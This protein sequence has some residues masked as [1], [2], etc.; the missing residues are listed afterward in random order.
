MTPDSNP[1]T[2]FALLRQTEMD[3]NKDKWIQGLDT[4][5]VTEEEAMQ[6]KEWGRILRHYKFNRIM[7]TDQ[8]RAHETASLVNLSLNLPLVQD[9]RLKERD[10]GTWSGKSIEQIRKEDPTL[11]EAQEQVGL[12]FC[13]PGGE[14]NTSLV[15]RISVALKEA[16]MK[17]VR[18]SILVVIHED[19]IKSVISHLIE[20]SWSGSHKSVVYLSNQL[21]WLTCYKG[22][23]ILE[24][25]NALPLPMACIPK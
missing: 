24:R 19:I 4:R 6:A 20:E 1:V 14:D 10:W 15:K 22:E 7:T 5:P 16:H 13:S 23:I 11:F 21:H 8:G 9:A 18:E 2:R 25:M 12:K 3:W 17:F